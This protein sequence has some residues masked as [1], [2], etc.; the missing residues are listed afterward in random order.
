[1][2]VLRAEPRNLGCHADVRAALIWARVRG[3]NTGGGVV[4]A[5]I[6]D[7]LFRYQVG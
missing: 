2:V 4:G 1:M 7:E 3:G 5:G 6:W